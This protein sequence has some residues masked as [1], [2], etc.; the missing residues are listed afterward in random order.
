VSFLRGEVVEIDANRPF[1]VFADGDP[2]ARLPATVTVA[3]QALRVI[4]PA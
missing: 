1:T 4:V 2:L 3:H